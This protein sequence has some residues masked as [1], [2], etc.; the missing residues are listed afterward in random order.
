MEAYSGTFK[1]VATRQHA[2][3]LPEDAQHVSRAAD[4]A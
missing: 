2:A 1:G 3:A 4:R